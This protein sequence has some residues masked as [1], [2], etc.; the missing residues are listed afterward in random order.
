LG[1]F[2]TITRIELHLSDE[3]AGKEGPE[4]IKCMLEARLEGKKPIAVSN[5]ADTNELA[6]DG[7]I[8]KLKTHLETILGKMKNY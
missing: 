7:A 6:V 8:N 2:K 4:D 1:R 5:F 3:N